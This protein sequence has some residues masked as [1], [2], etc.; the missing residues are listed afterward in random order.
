VDDDLRNIFAL[1]S[2]FEQHNMTVLHAETGHGGIETLRQNRDVE[3]VLMDI[4]MPGMDG[5]EA[6][7]TIRQLQGFES[8][9]IIA[10]TAKAMKN[11]REKCLKA[12]ASDYVSKPVDL[13]YLFSV[14]R[15]RLIQADNEAMRSGFAASQSRGGKLV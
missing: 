7:R 11:D 5:Y 15:V 4:M 9:P 8:V 3:L 10:L 14:M 12:G 2:V 6:T 1:T 13:T